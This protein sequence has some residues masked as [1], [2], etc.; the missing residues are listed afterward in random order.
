MRHQV[1]M[2]TGGSAG[3][4]RATAHEFAKRGAS[5][6]LIARG[7]EGLAGAKREIEKLGGR[8]RVFQLDVADSDAV[9]RAA[10]E[11]ETAFGPI[12]VWVNNAMSSV[13]SPIA[14]MTPAEF[15]RVTEVTY[16]GYVHGTL[17]ALKTMRPRNVGHIIQVGSALSW[18]SI[19]LQSAYCAAKHAVN[20]FTESLRTEL[21]HDNSGVKVNVVQMPALNTPQ[22]RWVLSRLSGLP[23]PVPPIFQPE[24]GARAILWTV[25]HPRKEVQVGFP[26][27]KAIL[28]EKFAARFADWYLARNGFESQ[29]LPGTIDQHERQT[30]LWKPV[31]YDPGTHGVFDERAL[32]SSVEWELVHNRKVKIGAAIAAIAIGALAIWGFRFRRETKAIAYSAG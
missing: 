18:R 19:P 28:G 22:F 25:D 10:E 4:G 12:D 8:V 21:L 31:D 24:V 17:A 13:F 23:Q 20:G 27:V 14:K 30:N 1:V 3:L 2:I 7:A 29:Q 32:D 6:G 5:I 16:L 15:R 11:L 26:T 9:F